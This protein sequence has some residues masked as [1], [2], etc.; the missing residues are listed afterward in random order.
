MPNG[1]TYVNNETDPIIVLVN[2]VEYYADYLADVCFK[3]S[4]GISKRN[5]FDNC[6]VGAWQC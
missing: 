2:D 6:T 1:F 5:I 3:K 4:M